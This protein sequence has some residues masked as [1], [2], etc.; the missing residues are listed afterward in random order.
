MFAFLNSA[1]QPASKK[2][3]LNSS[4]PSE[5][6]NLLW[7]TFGGN[8]VPGCFGKGSVRIPDLR[9]LEMPTEETNYEYLKLPNHDDFFPCD[10]HQILI[11]ETYKSLYA[12]LCET[13]LRIAKAGMF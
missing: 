7:H 4:E 8:T 5:K 2:C 1:D 3:R 6:W 10:L 9:M 13:R 12:L 11:T